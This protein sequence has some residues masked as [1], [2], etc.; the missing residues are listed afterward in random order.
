MTNKLGVLVCPFIKREVA[1]VLKSE[2]F[3]DVTVATFPARCYGPQLEWDDIAKTLPSD[4][5]YSQIIVVGSYCLARLQNITKEMEGCQVH[6]MTQCFSLLT[7]QDIINSYLKEKAY[8]LTPGWLAGWRARVNE[9]GFDDENDGEILRE[10]FTES[11]SKLLLLDTGVDKKSNERLQVFA[12][13]VGLP[14]DIVPIGLDFLRLFMTKI[15]LEWRLKDEK[16]QATTALNESRREMTDYAMAMDVFSDLAQVLTEVD[17]IERIFDL[18]SMLFAP[19]ELFYLSIQNGKPAEQV[20]SHS[21]WIADSAAVQ[22]RLENFAGEY[23]WVEAEA[24]FILRIGY[25]DE[26]VGILEVNG[27]AFPEYKERY[28]NLA[29]SFVGVCGLAIDNARKYQQLTAQKNQ[30]AQTLKELQETQQQ[31]VESEKMAALGNLVAGV[32][33]EINTPVGNS[34]MATSAVINRSQQLSA[35]YQDKA[36]KRADL[37]NYLQFVRQTTQILL[38]NLQRTG[39]LIKSFKQVSVDQAVE[40]RRQF[41]VKAYLQDVIRSLEPQLNTTSIQIVL[42]CDENLELNSYPGV[43]AQI[44][45]NLVINSIVHGFRGQNEGQITIECALSISQNEQLCLQYRDNGRGISA[46][47]LVK[48]FDPFFTTNKQIGTGLGLHIIYNIVTQ[49]LNGSINCESELG[50]GVLFIILVPLDTELTNE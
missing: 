38:S 13:F 43:F 37:E 7:N 22:N 26:T 29:V 30:L 3:N 24:S 12:D 4:M 45:T 5:D 39:D 41:K 31:L 28:L 23:A 47:N 17:A 50:D 33:H 18:F 35:L 8:L 19:K 40:S 20:R 32:A 49:K 15:V 46:D 42:D 14:F 6:C 34:I 36:M 10:F 27:I 48:I 21:G 2:D 9:L 1:T 25:R 11:A 16:E 44:I